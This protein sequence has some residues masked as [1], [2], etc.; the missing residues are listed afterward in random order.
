VLETTNTG[1]NHVA[2][3]HVR[4]LGVRKLD[5]VAV[6]DDPTLDQQR[7]GARQAQQTC[8]R[9]GRGRVEIQLC[10]MV[11]TRPIPA[12]ASSGA[13]VVTVSRTRLADGTALAIENA[14]LP[15]DCAGVLAVDLE[16]GSLQSSA[17]SVER[18][19]PPWRTVA[20]KRAIARS[21]GGSVCACFRE[22]PA[23]HGTRARAGLTTHHADV[24]R[25]MGRDLAWSIAAW[26]RPSPAA[27]AA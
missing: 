7:L 24:L 18:E 26:A 22:F 20:A 4:A 12:S 19:R 27:A 8:L 1:I 16:S 9:R 13:R 17:E 6:V 15:T 11:G 14:A 2:V 23:T 3:R 21:N 10:A 25:V 5:A